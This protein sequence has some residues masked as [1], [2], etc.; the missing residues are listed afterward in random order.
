M[1]FQF[2]RYMYIMHYLSDNNLYQEGKI[3]SDYWYERE[4]QWLWVL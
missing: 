4:R 2:D 1:V 3:L